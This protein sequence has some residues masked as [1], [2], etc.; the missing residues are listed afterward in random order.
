MNFATDASHNGVYK[1]HQVCHIMTLFHEYSMIKD[2]SEKQFIVFCYVQDNIGFLMK[3]KLIQ[4]QIP[5]CDVRVSGST[6]K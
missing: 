2:E 4:K 3:V 5:F 6:V 1:T